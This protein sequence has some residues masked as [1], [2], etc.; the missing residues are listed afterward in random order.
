MIKIKDFSEMFPFENEIV[1]KQIEG[2]SHAES[3]IQPQP[4]GNCM[5]WVLG[6]LDDSLLSLLKILDGKMPENLPDLKRYGYGSDPVR[7]D[8]PGVLPLKEL[9]SIYSLL[10]Q[11]ITDRLSQMTEADFKEEIDLWSGKTNR[12][13]GAL[14]YFFHTTYHIGQLEQGRNR[15]GKTEKVI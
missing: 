7:E 10:T 6:H 15:A 1:M 9:V 5:N 3:L 2:L 8:G 11:A 14:F 13:Y 4:G 12:G